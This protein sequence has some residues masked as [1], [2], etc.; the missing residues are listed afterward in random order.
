[1]LDGSCD[2]G[3]HV[4]VRKGKVLAVLHYASSLICSQRI[5]NRRATH[6]AAQ[7]HPASNSHKRQSQFLPVLPCAVP[8]LTFM[9]SD[10]R[11]L[12]LFSIVVSFLHS[13]THSVDFLPLIKPPSRR[14]R[15]LPHRSRPPFL[16]LFLAYYT[17]YLSC[18]SVECND[19]VVWYTRH[20]A[21]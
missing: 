6:H 12:P 20:A 21:R 10:F 9:S 15:R 3:I 8:T 5:E 4:E 1:M 19:D 2:I 13:T 14:S 16:V 7:T 18:L 17:H 11:P